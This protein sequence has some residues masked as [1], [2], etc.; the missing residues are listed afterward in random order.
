M[1]ENRQTLHGEDFCVT[2]A[3][4]C[5]HNGRMSDFVSPAAVK[6]AIKAHLVFH[7]QRPNAF[8]D[9]QLIPGGKQS[10]YV[11]TI[12]ASLLPPVRALLEDR[13]RRRCPYVEGSFLVY[14]NEVGGL[15]GR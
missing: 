3:H 1:F 13:L 7:S 2:S 11:I 9:V 4:G 8:V 6:A 14:G 15:L 5:W 12:D 10:V